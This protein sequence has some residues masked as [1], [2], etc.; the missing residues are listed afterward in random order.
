VFGVLS[1]A[2][3]FPMIHLVK[4]RWRI[5]DSLDVFAVHGVGGMTGSILL[6]I[7]IAPSLGGAGYAPGMDFTKQLE[8][9][10]LGVVVTALWSALASLALGWG[11]AKVLPM[12]ADA[13]EER[14]G[15]DI[16]AHG[17]RA[18]EMD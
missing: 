15:L 7:F 8:G 14:E 13:D 18:W 2:I 6:A 3:C 12:R 17:E 10:V 9:Q 1:V 16:T 4:N 11:V 5:D